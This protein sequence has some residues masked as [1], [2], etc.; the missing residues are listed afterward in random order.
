MPSELQSFSQSPDTL[1][2]CDSSDD[3]SLF[4]FLLHSNFLLAVELCPE[5]N[6]AQDMCS[7]AGNAVGGQLLSYQPPINKTIDSFKVMPPFGEAHI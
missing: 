2:S 4:V 3:N 1:P 6:P 7:A 5:S